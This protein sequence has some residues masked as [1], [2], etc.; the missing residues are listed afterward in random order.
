MGMNMAKMQ[1]MEES[2]DKVNVE[3]FK[4]K[5]GLQSIHIGYTLDILDEVDEDIMTWD[6]KAKYAEAMLLLN[7]ITDSLMDERKIELA[8][9]RRQ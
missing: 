4:R 5:R 2:M 7:S 6:E 3:D 1:D 9:R 8:L